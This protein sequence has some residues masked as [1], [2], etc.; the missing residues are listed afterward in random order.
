MPIF[1]CRSFSCYY[2][3][4]NTH[5]DEMTERLRKMVNILIEEYK[6]NR[7]DDWHWFESLLA[8]DNAM[9]PLSL[10][11]AVNFLNDEA[12]TNVA[13][14]SMHFLSTLTLKEGYLSVVGNETW[15]IKNGSPSMF[16]QQPLDVLATV[17]MFHQAFLLTKEKAFLDKLYISF[18]WFLG[19]NDLRI[20]LYDFETKGCCDGLERS[21]INRNQ[22]A[23]STLAY[24]ISHL[25]V[26]EAFEQYYKS[27]N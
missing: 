24:L 2:L 18:M 5:D 10:L 16:A 20:S 3:K 11:H 6:K 25:T 12:V 15:Y 8:Y 9:L 22:G 1:G 4:N 13:M 23:E 21:G 26:L 7:T 14:E 17:L 27:E 19:E